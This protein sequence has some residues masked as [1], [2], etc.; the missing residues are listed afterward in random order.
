M[1]LEIQLDRP[2]HAHSPG[3]ALTGAV[4]LTCRKPT[5]HQGVTLRVTGAVALSPA[6]RKI[7]L[8]DALTAPA[9][10]TQLMDISVSLMGPGP[11]P[12]GPTL[13]PFEVPLRPMAPRG[14]L[15]ETYHGVFVSVQYAATAEV[16]QGAFFRS[17]IT[18]QPFLVI[19]PGQGAGQPLPRP[20][21]LTLE[22]R[23]LRRTGLSTHEHV[24]RFSIR[25]Q[26]DSVVC[27]VSRPFTGT[28]CVA[29]SEVRV[30]R[31][32]L[33]LVRVEFCAAPTGVTKEATE[34]Q[35]LQVAEGDVCRGLD[36]P[37]HMVFPRWFACPSLVTPDFK[38]EFE[39]NLVI[40][41]EDQ[42]QL[43][44]NLPLWLYRPRR[45]LSPT[46]PPPAASGR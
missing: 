46:A 42:H 41:F 36:I 25:G 21:A 30:A 28:L 9:M 12:A 19:N 7:G 26:V 23:S 29:H 17:L 16:Q 5:S 44:D 31:I 40:V 10:A 20:V 38:V 4:V 15:H 35:T 43:T 27:D 37:L 22:P 14:A 24:P 13:L 33:Q 3:E 32:D 8:F 1:Q 34:V 6:P 39:V 2:S 45:S 11:L 18:K